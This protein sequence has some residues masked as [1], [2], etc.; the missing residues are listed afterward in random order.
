MPIEREGKKNNSK[1][2]IFNMSMCSFA[3]CARCTAPCAG[4]MGGE[5]VREPAL[6]GEAAM[7]PGG[8]DRPH[9]TLGAEAHDTWAPR[10]CAGRVAVECC[11]R[12][13]GRHGSP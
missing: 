13:T 10:Q 5:P 7:G 9:V 4:L 11:V 8:M 3:E 6:P 2:L 1:Q 12:S